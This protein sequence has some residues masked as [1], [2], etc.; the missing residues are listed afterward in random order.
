MLEMGLAK[1]YRCTKFE[2]SNFTRYKLMDFVMQQT[3]LPVGVARSGYAG[4][5]K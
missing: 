1:V 5:K 2:V 4:F 3:R